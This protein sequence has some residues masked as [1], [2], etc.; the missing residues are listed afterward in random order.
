MNKLVIQNV[1]HPFFIFDEAIGL[2]KTYESFQELGTMLTDVEITDKTEIIVNRGP[3]SYSGIR[4]S[5]AY[6][7]G[8][9]HGHLIAQRNI[10]TFTTF[11]FTMF[12]QPL[13]FIAWPR[14]T[15]NSIQDTKGY[16]LDDISKPIRYISGVEA[17]EIPKIK[18]LAERSFILNS[19]IPV[20]LFEDFVNPS[21]IKNFLNNS[22]LSKDRSPL[23]I[24][25]VFITV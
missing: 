3:G 1:F 6:V 17:L 15:V 4:T 13:Y 5:L 25:P 9:E 22:S 2:L 19:E 7:L 14:N 10:S 21:H 20:Q 16:T 11:D 8:L 23:Y 12:I 24:N 18:M